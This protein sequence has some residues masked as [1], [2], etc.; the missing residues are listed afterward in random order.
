MK[1]AK[2][3]MLVLAWLAYLAF[4]GPALISAKD[5]F[6]VAL[7]FV[8]PLGLSYITYKRISVKHEK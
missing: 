4:V 2:D 7:G 5:W 6:A 1:N 8:I 3:W